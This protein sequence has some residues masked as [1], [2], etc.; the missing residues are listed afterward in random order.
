MTGNKRGR[1]E[2][3]MGD[4]FGKAQAAVL[5]ELSTILRSVDSRDM[6]GLARAVRDAKNICSYGV[7]RE[8]LALKAFTI[9]LHNLGFK[10]YFVGDTNTPPL[11]SGDLFLVSAGP[12]YYS[13]VICCFLLASVLMV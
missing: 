12:S 8:G 9:N 5:E 3:E 2:E 10:A 7:S 4:D 6:I 11:S 13:T 1:Q